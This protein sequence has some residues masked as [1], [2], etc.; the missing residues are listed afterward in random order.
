MPMLDDKPSAGH[1]NVADGADLIRAT[2]HLP[3]VDIEVARWRFA[4]AEHVAV[5][6]KATPSFDAVGRVFEAANPFA[7]W[8]R[9]AELVWLPWLAA[10]RTLTTPWALPPTARRT[11]ERDS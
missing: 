5:S 11:G 7:L 10:A 3:G 8:M 1:D 4:H 6:L 2:A 9:C